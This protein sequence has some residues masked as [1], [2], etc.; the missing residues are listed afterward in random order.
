MASKGGDGRRRV[1][2]TAWSGITYGQVYVAPSAL[3]ASIY[4]HR[5]RLPAGVKTKRTMPLASHRFLPSPFLD[6]QCASSSLFLNELGTYL[7]FYYQLQCYGPLLLLLL[8]LWARRSSG[9]KSSTSNPV[10]K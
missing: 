4:L 5:A 1:T 7:P 10:N 9:A 8:F 6:Q 2:R 3:W